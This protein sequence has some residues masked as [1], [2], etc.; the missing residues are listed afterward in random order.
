[1]KNFFSVC[2]LILFSIAV[3]SQ[4]PIEKYRFVNIKESISQIGVP[5]IIQDHY[6][7]IWLGTSGVG[8]N[9]FDGSDYKTYKFKPNDPTSLSNNVINC[10]YLDNNNR[11]W[12]GTDDGLNL[13][14]YK[15][16]CFKR[17]LLS[18]FKKNKKS[19]FANLAPKLFALPKPKLVEDSIML[20][21]G[22]LFLK[23]TTESSF[24]ALSTTIIWNS[25]SFV[26]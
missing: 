1:M 4:K 19:P 24:E 16:D 17:I 25:T 7:F 12:F 6:G 21:N 14:D 10:S 8:L 22:K 23:N 18:E 26:C 3:W 13:Y 9:K 5:S 11:L 20:I 15:N 2:C